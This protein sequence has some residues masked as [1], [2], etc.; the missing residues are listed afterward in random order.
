MDRA[1]SFW[2][3]MSSLSDYA[4]PSPARATKPSTPKGPSKVSSL[5]I[6][7]SDNGG[8]TVTQEF[9]PPANS[10]GPWPR[11]KSHVF[12][13]VESMTDFVETCFGKD[14]DKS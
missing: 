7:R 1:F 11:T 14:D 12:T 4:S 9:R 6:E 2:C 3:D 13:D 5:R 8:F 10:D